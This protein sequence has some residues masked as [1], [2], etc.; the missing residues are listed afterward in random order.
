MFFV[1]SMC[2]SSAITRGV[3]GLRRGGGGGGAME[4]PAV[5]VP[6]VDSLCVPANPCHW[7]LDPQRIHGAVLWEPLTTPCRGPIIFW[8]AVAQLVGCH[9]RRRWP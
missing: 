4:I 1:S 7:Q 3:E 8:E 9:L 5:R 6:C 2:H